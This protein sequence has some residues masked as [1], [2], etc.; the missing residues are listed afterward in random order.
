LA[1]ATSAATCSGVSASSPSP[2]GGGAGVRVGDGVALDALVLGVPVDVGD[3]V[4]VGLAVADALAV[5]D[6]VPEALSASAADA[7]AP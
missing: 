1:C 5:G 3:D 7:P 4:V 2:G 6:D